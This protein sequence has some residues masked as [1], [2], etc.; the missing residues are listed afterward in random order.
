[1]TGI[2]FGI[3]MTV[4]V[5]SGIPVYFSAIDLAKIWCL[6]FVEFDCVPPS[7]VG[8]GKTHVLRRCSCR[9]VATA[10]MSAAMELRTIGDRKMGSIMIPHLCYT[11]NEVI[12][13]D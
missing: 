13:V 3:L 7:G 8:C 11:I 2:P 9:T 4:M 10:A 1:M 6:R 12:N 5:Y